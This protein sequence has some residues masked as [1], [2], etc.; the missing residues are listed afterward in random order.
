MS[1]AFKFSDPGEGLEEAEVLE[2]H[3]GEGDQVNDGDTVLTVET[4]KAAT[5]IPAPFTGKVERIHVK[6]GDTVRVDDLLISYSP[7]GSED[8]GSGKQDKEE[9]QSDASDGDDSAKSADKDKTDKNED[10]QQQASSAEPEDEKGATQPRADANA[11]EGEEN[12]EQGDTRR[13]A[14]SDDDSQSEDSQHQA[15]K[16]APVPA[17]PSTRRIARERGVDLHAID[18]SGPHGRVTTEDVE[19][20]ARHAGSTGGSAEP[21]DPQRGPQRE[22]TA[23]PDF[24]RWGETERQPMRSIRRATAKRM[25]QSWREIPHVYHQDIVDVTELERFRHDYETSAEADGG[26]FTMTLLML[27][28]MVYA[29]KQFPRFNASLDQLAQARNSKPWRNI[30]T[31]FTVAFGLILIKDATTL[32]GGDTHH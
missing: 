1:E 6:I 26:K 2:I 5:D 29:L 8:A 11:E 10:R 12:A 3:V 24:S 27:K 32:G 22:A 23:L 19:A 7:E 17:A 30:V 13:E 9:A 14:A 20:A 28:A 31:V 4:D 21:K 25:A 18:P 16:R 15:D